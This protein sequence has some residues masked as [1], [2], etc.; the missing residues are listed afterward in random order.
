MEVAEKDLEEA[1]SEIELALE[2][3]GKSIADVAHRMS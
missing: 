3:V 1:L 2:W